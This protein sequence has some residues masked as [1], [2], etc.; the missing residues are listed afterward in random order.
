MKKISWV[1]NRRVC[2]C[3]HVSMYMFD[4][5]SHFINAKELHGFSTPWWCASHF[6]GAIRWAILCEP[7]KRGWCSS[8]RFIWQNHCL[9]EQVHGL[10]TIVAWW[11]SA[12][13]M[14]AACFISHHDICTCAV[15]NYP[16]QN[17]PLSLPKPSEIWGG[18]M[19]RNLLDGSE[20]AL[21]PWHVWS[22]VLELDG[23]T[24]DWA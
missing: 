12:F 10:G 4:V 23:S 13:N 7:C 3:A 18:N 20:V 15:W 2:V 16:M 5:S 1:L 24:C 14:H 6:G 21:W 11:I 19:P 17:V 8:A 9:M 22:D